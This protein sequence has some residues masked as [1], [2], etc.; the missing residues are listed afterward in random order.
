MLRR[1]C[2]HPTLLCCCCCWATRVAWPF[3]W[4]SRQMALQQTPWMSSGPRSPQQLYFFTRYGRL[5]APLCRLKAP[6]SLGHAR[7]WIMN[8][9][10][11]NHSTANPSLDSWGKSSD[12]DD[13]LLLSLFFQGLGFHSCFLIDKFLLNFTRRLSSQS[14]NS[15]PITGFLRKLKKKMLFLWGKRSDNDIWLLLSLLSGFRV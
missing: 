11:S 15:K 7:S 6:F 14:S 3:G 5:L 2:R 10:F 13:W 9:L 8:P 4:R 1:A 12:D